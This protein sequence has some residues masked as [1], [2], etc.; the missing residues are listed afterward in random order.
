MCQKQAK[1]YIK[2]DRNKRDAEYRQEG[3]DELGI[4]DKIIA[5][6]CT[7]HL[8]CL[9]VTSGGLCC[10]ITPLSPFTNALAFA[11]MGCASCIV[12]G[13]I[14]YAVLAKCPLPWNVVNDRVYNDMGPLPDIMTAREEEPMTPNRN[15]PMPDIIPMI[16]DPAAVQLLIGVIN[17]PELQGGVETIVTQQPR[18]IGSN[19]S[20][21]RT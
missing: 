4:V 10:V 7:S 11:G 14:T 5:T 12:S 18:G 8:T 17:I 20:F 2:D 13:G 3:A 19:G 15:G 16:A 21:E 1:E 9:S 6:L